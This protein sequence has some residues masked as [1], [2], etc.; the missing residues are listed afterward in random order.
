MGTT[1]RQFLTRDI[2]TMDE[3]TTLSSPTKAI[4]TDMKV[5]VALFPMEGNILPTRQGM[6]NMEH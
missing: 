6:V 3:D 1:A 4:L 2:T 5:M